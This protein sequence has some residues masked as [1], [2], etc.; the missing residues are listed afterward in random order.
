[1]KK[2]FRCVCMVICLMAFTGCG[3]KSL[4]CV[5]KTDNDNMKMTQEYK[6]KFNKDSVKSLFID[7]DVDFAEDSIDLKDNILQ[8]VRDKFSSYYDNSGIAYS[9]SDKSNGFD[10]QIKINFN[11]LDKDAKSKVDIINYAESYEMIKSD[12]EQKDFICK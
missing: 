5:K 3:G 2:F 8:S 12:L 9:I 10:F 7:I 6:I 4:K 1:M 11:K